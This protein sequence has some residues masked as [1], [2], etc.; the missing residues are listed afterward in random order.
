VED[1]EDIIEWLGW[2]FRKCDTNQ[3]TVTSL[4]LM[5]LSLSPFPSLSLSLSACLSDRPSDSTWHAAPFCRPQSVPRRPKNRR[6][7][8][9]ICIKTKF[10]TIILTIS[11]LQDGALSYH[12]FMNFVRS[13]HLNLG[14]KEAFQFFMMADLDNDYRII[15]PE[16]VVD[17]PIILQK[18]GMRR[19]RRRRMM[20]MMVVAVRRMVVMMMMMMMVVVV[21]V[22][23]V[24]IVL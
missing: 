16:I 3:V 7:T 9:S 11:S 6:E 21:V 15:W 8:A 12:E 4:S 23:V 22:V 10:L 14:P 24:L 13:L 5:F 20:M 2:E 17:V 19:R 18:V 1:Y